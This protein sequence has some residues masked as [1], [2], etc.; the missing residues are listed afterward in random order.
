[1]R[2]REFFAGL[3]SMAVLPMAARAQQGER[4]RRIGVLLG[5]DENAIAQAW[6]SGFTRGIS[7]L[8]WI[9]GRDLRMDLRWAAGNVDRMRSLAK[10]LVGL[11][12][13]LILA[14]Y[15]AG[16]RCAPTRDAD[17]PDCIC[18]HLRPRRR[19]FRGE[20]SAPRWEYYRFHQHRSGNRRQVAGVAHRDRAHYQAGRDDVQSR[21]GARW[22]FLLSSGLRGCCPIV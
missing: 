11:A 18:G 5:W 17:H 6:F 15:D 12:P 8:G 1:M 9:D 7:E 4:V 2:R 14:K 3:V 10:E 22:R 21:H 16:N 20:L 13:D 19:W